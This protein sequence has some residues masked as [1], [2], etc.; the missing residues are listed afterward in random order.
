MIPYGKNDKFHMNFPDN[1]PKKG[2]VNW[3]EVELGDV[4]KKSA[5]QKAKREMLKEV[6][7]EKARDQE[8]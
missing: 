4:N 5:R 3:W 1:H 2:W 6:E 8:E 7:N